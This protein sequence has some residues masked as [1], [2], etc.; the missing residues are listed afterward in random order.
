LIFV[1][2]VLDCFPIRLFAQPAGGLFAPRPSF[3]VTNH[4]V[5]VSVFHWFTADGDQIGPWQPIEGRTNWTG[6]PTFWR[7]QL[8]QMMAANI[9]VL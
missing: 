5:S 1:I 6:D 4:L 2:F 7:S 9:D 3:S 8:K